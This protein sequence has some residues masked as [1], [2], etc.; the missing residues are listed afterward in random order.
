MVAVP[1]DRNSIT[2]KNAVSRISKRMEIRLKTPEFPRLEKST[3]NYVFSMGFY[4]IMCYNIPKISRRGKNMTL[5][6]GERL[7]DLRKERGLTLD[8][9][10]EATKISRS[11]LGKY[12]SDEFKDISPFSIVTLAKF[13]GVT[14]DYLMGLTETRNRS[15]EG[16]ADL[17]LSDE[18]LDLLR[19]RRV[20]T[21][22]L[23][24][25]V[26]HKD[27]EKLLADIEIYVD[28]IATMQIQNLNAWVDVAR[29]EIIEKYHPGEQ[30]KTMRI[31]DAVHIQ[32]GEYFA[33][34]VR[35]DLDAILEDLHEA[36]RGKRDSA[37]ESSV[38][39]EFKRDLEEVANFEGSELERW[40]LLF[41]KAN[42]I[43]YKKL[44]EEEKQWLIRI[45][46]KSAL[47]KSYIP[48]RGKKR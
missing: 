17:G 41:C 32:E 7:E 1:R 38:I 23:S 26:T 22:L 13:Y 45:G 39:A 12:E 15:N 24:E 6:I 36:H 9:L 5:T 8:E 48:Q 19:E 4:K 40:L 46:R 10:A 25:L 28:G 21:A 30:D 34:R 44:T 3:E 29:T 31:L 18:M 16:L 2:E 11:A 14:A 27:F 33:S 20:N 42:R 47:M 35:E 43:I 37:P